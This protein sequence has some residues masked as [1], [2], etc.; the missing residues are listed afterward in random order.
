M[1]KLFTLTLLFTSIALFAQDAKE[2][3]TE[4]KFTLS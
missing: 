4:K 2:E 3:T 1:K